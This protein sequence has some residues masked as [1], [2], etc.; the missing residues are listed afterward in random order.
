VGG[1]FAL[2]NAGPNAWFSHQHNAHYIDDH[3]L[4]LFDNGN[5]RRPRDPTANS[6]G[7]V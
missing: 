1:D 3:T 5:T 2:D 6:R 7:Q 4:I